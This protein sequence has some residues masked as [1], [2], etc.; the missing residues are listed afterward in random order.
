[1]H[2]NGK[3]LAIGAALAATASL[4]AAQSSL[5][6]AGAVDASVRRVSNSVGSITS[7]SSGNNYSSTLQFRG[8][9]DLGGGMHAGF[10]LEG[11]IFGDSGAGA[12]TGG[13]FMFDRRSTV[14]IGSKTW[15]EVRL[16]REWT[17]VFY[18][19][20]FGDPFLAV[21][22]GSSANFLSTFSSTPLS[23]A[24]GVASPNSTVSRS[25]NAVQYHLPSGLGGVYGSVMYS[26][27]ENANATN[28]FDY[29]AA[30][31]GWRSGPA[32]V[33]V[34]GGSTHIDATGENITQQG[35]FAAYNFG[36]P[37]AT[38]SYTQTKYLSSKSSQ[39]IVGVSVPVQQ[40]VFRVS[41]N[42]FD[43]SGSNAAGASIGAND[44]DQFAV[45]AV[46]NL[47]KR[48]AVYSNVARLKNK[49]TANFAIPGGPGGVAAGSSSRGYE[50][51]VRHA[52]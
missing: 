37:R 45:G 14:S 12:A 40:W 50:F 19:M 47:S 3:T 4:A 35:V 52:F 49:G 20:A 32:D 2:I 39:L 28:N 10:W 48:T 9:E 18:G 44:A 16:G 30:R 29:R 7:L 23:R 17:P 27:G 34:Y 15:G 46:Y 25:S 5:T 51:G 31:L 13:G 11:L 41:Y 26:F 8:Q 33:A 22:V 42:R 43:H 38:G 24:F 36:G 21:G 1:M 6:I